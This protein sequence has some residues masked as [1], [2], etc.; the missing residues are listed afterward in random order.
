MRSDY[1]LVKE[2]HEKFEIDIGETPHIPT[3]QVLAFRLELIDEELKE[4]FES[5]EN[6]DLENFAQELADVLYVVNGFAV[7]AG[8]DVHKILEEVHRSNMT[9]LDENGK[10]NK[11]A[12]GKVLKG[13]NYQKPNIKKVLK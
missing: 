6:N 9:K 12:D 8:I 7:T 5:I 2:F 4:L 1:D 3:G 13:P 11:R 10:V